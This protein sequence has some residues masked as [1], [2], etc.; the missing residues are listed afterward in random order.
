MKENIL[1]EAE[2]EQLNQN[3]IREKLEMPN[4]FCIGTNKLN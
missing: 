2:F 1:N 3:N 4:S